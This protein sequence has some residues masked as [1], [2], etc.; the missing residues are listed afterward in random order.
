[1]TVRSDA[2]NYVRDGS[3]A[4]TNFG[5]AQ[6]MEVKRVNAPGW[7]RET[8]LSFDLSNVGEASGIASAKVRLFGNKL[9][10]IVSSMTVGL[11]PVSMAAWNESALTW[12][13]K[14]ASAATPIATANVASSAGQ[15]YEFDVTNYLKQQ[16]AAGATRAAFAVKA[17]T[18]SEGWAGFNSDEATAN[19][20]ELIVGQT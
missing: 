9:D 13:N 2:D 10:S 17:Q 18:V 1:M 8:Y 15:W 5:T 3:H 7:T 19:R 14:P 11:H 12:D 6:R 4:G 16:K 20:P